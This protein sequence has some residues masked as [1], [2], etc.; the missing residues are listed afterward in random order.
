MKNKIFKPTDKIIN[1]KWDTYYYSVPHE[2][3]VLIVLTSL[4]ENNVIT[5]DKLKGQVRSLRD[6]QLLKYRNTYHCDINDRWYN[7]VGMMEVF[8]DLFNIKQVSFLKLIEVLQLYT[9]TNYNYCINL[10]IGKIINPLLDRFTYSTHYDYFG[11]LFTTTLYDFPNILHKGYKSE[12]YECGASRFTNDEK[13]TKEQISQIIDYLHYYKKG[14]LT[15][16][17]K[18]VPLNKVIIF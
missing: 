8:E 18:E 6:K 11:Q 14:T 17:P 12:C 2:F 13:K 3:L 10:I 4:Y 16:I 9:N 1:I 5:L 15:K 7:D